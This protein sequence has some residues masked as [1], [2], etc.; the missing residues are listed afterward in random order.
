MKK[1]VCRTINS[2]FLA[3]RAEEIEDPRVLQRPA[4]VRHIPRQVQH[5]A[6]GD[7]GFLILGSA[8]LAQPEST[9][10]GEDHNDLLVVVLMRGEIEPLCEEHLGDHHLLAD[11]AAALDER[12]G[13]VLGQL[14]ERVLAGG[15]DR[16][17]FHSLPGCIGERRAINCVTLIAISKYTRHAMWYWYW[18][19]AGPTVMIVLG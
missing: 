9:P 6:P 10:P 19:I 11:D 18:W 1:S 2:G 8:G 16:L 17:L 3:H 5:I 4:R 14:L 7:L 12:H 13:A 15:H